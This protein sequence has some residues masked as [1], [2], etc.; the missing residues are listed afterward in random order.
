M[1]NIA[2]EAMVHISSMVLR[3]E[4]IAPVVGSIKQTQGSTHA[5]PWSAGPT[6]FDIEERKVGAMTA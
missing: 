3:K 1:K 2:L 4:N 6:S 5:L